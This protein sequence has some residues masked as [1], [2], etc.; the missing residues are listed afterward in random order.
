MCCAAITWAVLTSPVLTFFPMAMIVQ[1]GGPA[2]LFVARTMW[3]RYAVFM[4]LPMI[5]T[6]MGVKGVNY[7]KQSAELDGRGLGIAAIW[8]G[9]VSLLVGSNLTDP[10]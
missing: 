2:A 3:L 5:G 8:I 9:V 10:V 4:G 7:V 6:F 1:A